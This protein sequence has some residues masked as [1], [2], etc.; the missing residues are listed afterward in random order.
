MRSTEIEEARER[1]ANA[2]TPEEPSRG[3]KRLLK[4]ERNK[5]LQ[6]ILVGTDGL[7]L[8][9]G[10]LSPG[11]GFAIGPAF[12]KK[13][14]LEGML[15]A[16]FGFRAS[17]TGAY[18][19]SGFLRLPH[20]WNDHVFVE[21]SAVHR[22]LNRQ[23]YYG[24]GPESKRTGRS[25]F[26]LED[27]I[28]ESRVGIQPVSGMR[29]GVIGGIYAANVGPGDTSTFISAERQFSPLVT[30]GI[31]RQGSFWRS[32][33]FTEYDWRRGG[34]ETT[35]GGRYRAEWIRNSDRDYG[36]Y[37]HNRFDLDAT[38]YQP[39]L[40]K[41]HVLALHAHSTLTDVRR[42]QQLP[43]YLQP[44]L[45]GPDTLRGFAPFRF[46]GD[47]SVLFNFEYRWEASAGL[48][49]ALFADGG[50]VFRKWEQLNFHGLES[51]FG[52]GLRFK[53][54]ENLA[55]RI[56]IGASRE[57]VRIWFRFNNAF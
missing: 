49:V 8:A 12:R 41:T 15:D 29:L 34:T 26:R 18:L 14:L 27:T 19:G 1:K 28:A 11:A 9:I 4:F 7:R 57:G 6:G 43:F 44:T 23:P 42:D 52:A 51:S 47:N 53:M 46:Y 3:E 24:P 55:T 38:H 33:A 31:D 10:G 48:D 45:G 36:R 50:K 13:E 2:L 25:A 16:G 22:N 35:G 20:L 5:W 56:D 37:S 21:T 17:P 32:G 40:N 54:R 39:F 30:P